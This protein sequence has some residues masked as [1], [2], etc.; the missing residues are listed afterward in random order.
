MSFFQLNLETM[1]AQK[2]LFLTKLKQDFAV[3]Y[4]MLEVK[5]SELYSKINQAFEECA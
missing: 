4:K 3:M 5:Y 1:K 2:S